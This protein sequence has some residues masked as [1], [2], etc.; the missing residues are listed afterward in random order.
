MV[1]VLLA[2]ALV[3]SSPAAVRGAD[4]DD[5]PSLSKFDAA[6]IPWY[7][8]EGA[9]QPLQSDALANHLPE[10]LHAQQANQWVTVFMFSA[11]A[12][13]W[14][15]NCVYS[16][17]KFG[18]ANNYIVAATDEASL[19]A[20]LQLRLPCYNASSAMGN[21]ELD[22]VWAKVAVAKQVLDLGYNVHYSDVDVVY[23]R[24][25]WP[26]YYRLFQK[27]QPDA[28]FMNETG[29]T[30]LDPLPRRAA[31]VALAVDPPTGYVNLLNTGV[32]AM[33]SNVVTRRLMATWLGMR[34]VGDGGGVSSSSSAGWRGNQAPLNSRAFV[35]YV[36]CEVYETCATAR[37]AGLPAV[38]RH[39]PQFGSQRGPCP[40]ETLGDVP[41]H[42]D[43]LFVHMNCR[44]KWPG[45]L[46]WVSMAQTLESYRL[47]L[48]DEQLRPV[49]NE[50]SPATRHPFLPCKGPAWEST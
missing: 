49:Y 34:G 43:T 33:R 11:D 47:M 18:E 48:L 6:H 37:Q 28:I 10:L 22:L 7:N 14:V 35:D 40:M 4:G 39:P 29:G 15:L 13:R 17:I 24:P 9:G 38:F 5:G 30:G 25:V 3:G 50:D 31:D 12:Q 44:S 46:W 20:C 45:W 16:Y 2:A 21:S 1:T 26:S 41:C 32:F 19:Q 27:F 42:K 23:M 8:T 36:P